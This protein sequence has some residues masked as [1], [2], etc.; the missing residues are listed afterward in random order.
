M[1]IGAPPISIPEPAR[2]W[3]TDLARQLNDLERKLERPSRAP[4][5]LANVT[6]L[7]TLDGGTATADDVRQGLVTLIRDLTT[8]NIL[9]TGRG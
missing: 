3:L 1:T 5:S 7:R 6:E 8:A 9:P 2:R 4:W